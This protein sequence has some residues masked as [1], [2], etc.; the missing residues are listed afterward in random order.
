[1]E[2]SSPTADA[3]DPAK[4]GRSP[5]SPAGESLQ[6]ADGGGPI[7]FCQLVDFLKKADEKRDAAEATRAAAEATRH[8]EA[9]EESKKK[10]VALA[11][12][13]RIEERLGRIEGSLAGLVTLVAARSGRCTG[14][15]PSL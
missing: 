10:P 1:M 13:T 15:P 2:Q 4:S 12:L 11:A 5:S 9:M 3:A 6:Q 14:R 7:D 8:K